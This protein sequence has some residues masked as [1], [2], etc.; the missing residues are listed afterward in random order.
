MRSFISGN[1]LYK[2]GIFGILIFGILSINS[3]YKFDGD[4]TA[5]S[6][7]QIDT[8]SINTYY[9]EQGSATYNITDAWVYVDDNLIGVF[10]LPAVLPILRNGPQN[11]DVRSGIKLNG[12]SSTRVP[13]PFYEKIAF[14][15]LELF[16]DSVVSLGRVTT[17]YKSDLVFSWMEDFEDSGL[18]LEEVSFSDTA[19]KRTSPENNPEAYLSEYS[20]YSG[21]VNITEEKPIW[22]S[23]SLSTYP[24]TAQGAPVVLELDYKNDNYFNVGLLFKEYGQFVKIPLYTINH[25][26]EWNKIYLNLGPNITL[27]QQAEYFQVVIEAGLDNNKSKGTIYLDNI[28]LIYWPL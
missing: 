3:C 16:E 24:I 4:Q 25:S 23:L 12:I 10:E 27:H 1:S 28:K 11:I 17:S 7:L 26:E 13:Y 2:L 6:Y 14:E 22:S 21:I 8:I 20:R 9:A 5:P 19:I 18:T 15:G